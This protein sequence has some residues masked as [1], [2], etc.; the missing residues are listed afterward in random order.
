MIGSRLF[1]VASRHTPAEKIPKPQSGG[2][3]KPSAASRDREAV[4]G[5]FRRI[6]GPLRGQNR[7]QKPK[8]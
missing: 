1:N 8:P 6:V 7:G 2:P 4:L 5:D 3:K